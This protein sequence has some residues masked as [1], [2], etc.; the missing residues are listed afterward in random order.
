ML[1]AGLIDVHKSLETLSTLIFIKNTTDFIK[2]FT[3]RIKQ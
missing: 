3:P 1:T 2:N